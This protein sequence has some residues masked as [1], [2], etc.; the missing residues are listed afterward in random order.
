[1]YRFPRWFSPATVIALIALFVALGGTGYALSSLPRNSVGSAQVID[2]SLRTADLSRSAVAALRGKKGPAGRVGLAGPVGATGPKGEPG[3]LAFAHVLADGTI[4]RARSTENVLAVTKAIVAGTVSV[5]LYCFDL[6]VTTKNI[7][8]TAEDTTVALP[9][10]MQ[11]VGIH[12]PT[13]NATIDPAVIA[14]FGCV[15]GTDAAVVSG[16][17]TGEPFYALFN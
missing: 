9:P 13:I 3:W 2:D 12:D 8:V 1:M 15:S 7:V 5:Q 10:P 6:A 11:G 14:R 16:V 17:G 4:D